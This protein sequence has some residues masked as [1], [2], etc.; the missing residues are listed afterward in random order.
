MPFSE[1]Q[2]KAVSHLDGPMLVLA[3]PGSGK[4]SVITGRT[5]RLTEQ[6][7]SPSSILVVTFTRAA[8]AEMKGRFLKA[9]HQSSTQVAF[10]TFHSVYYAILRNAQV[11]GCG[12]ILPESKKLQLIREIMDHT[13]KGGT[14]EN[15]LPSRVAREI[16]QVRGSGIDLQNFYSGVLP[17]DVF[18]KVYTLYENWKEENSC[19]DFDDII[20]KCRDLFVERPDVLARWQKRFRYVLVDEFQDIS[21]LQYEVIRMIAA[22]ENNLFIVGDD[23]QSI[24]RF[25]GANPGI[26]LG[27][28]KDYPDAEI[29]TLNENYRC[30]PQV[31]QAS[32]RLIEKNKKRY[33]KSIRAVRESG[34][35]VKKETFQ[36]PQEECRHLAET[37]RMN[38]D[39]A[40]T[41]YKDMAVLSRTNSGCREAVEQLM[42]N[43]IPFRMGDLIPCVFDHWIAK[44]IM[45][46][47]DLGSG[48]RKRSDFLRIYNRPNRYFSR[49][50]FRRNIVPFSDLYNYY[51]DKDWMCRRVQTFEDQIGM[52][53][54][55]AP[56]GAITFIRREVGYEAYVRDYATEHRIDPEDLVRILDELTE[57]AK[58]FK[59]LSEWKE[60]IRRFRE[61]RE[62]R[63]SRSQKTDGVTVCTLHGSKGMEYDDVYILDVN[64]GVIPYHK[65]VLEEDLEE[66]RRMLYV[67]MTRAK[68]RLFL[69]SVRTRYEK[70]AE[71][72][73]FLK[74]IFG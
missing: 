26:M 32:A 62:E 25:R 31:I 38:H 10:G 18:R 50:A 37:L 27:F 64:E 35:P 54:N 39:S 6:G 44:D 74:D 15:D 8:A 19:I 7:I 12:Q 53:G 5:V 16:G 2:S 59:T 4:T 41:P 47:M 61:K 30:T 33:Q 13:W 20:V 24:Y 14:E 17:Q 29:V 72:S 11:P 46:Y 43:E 60:S 65:A 40:G 34:A 1:S 58:N 23:D 21:P 3:G 9:V 68:K 73:R 55:L 51:E 36:N 66:E 70:K 63:L 45:A 57:S 67:G 22:P 49:D 48:S 42:A 56:F 69:Y 71:P 28:P 52:I